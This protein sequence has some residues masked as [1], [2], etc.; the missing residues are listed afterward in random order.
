MDSQLAL[1]ESIIRTPNQVAT[2]ARHRLDNWEPRIRRI[3]A[4]L[5]KLDWFSRVGEASDFA[6]GN[7]HIRSL[8]RGARRRVEAV[9]TTESAL[10]LRRDELVIDDR[11]WRLLAD[12]G[13][14]QKLLD[15]MSAAEE[16]WVASFDFDFKS[17]RL[18]QDE[19]DELLPFVRSDIVG[20]LREAILGDGVGIYYFS[21]ALFWYRKGH[22]RCALKDGVELVY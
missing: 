1:A 18:S 9:Q 19:L 4:S 21:D 2:T 12:L 8:R 5:N 17:R 6:N 3:V 14:D 11:I 22:L 13:K 16:Y 20:A 7:G 10:A 15:V